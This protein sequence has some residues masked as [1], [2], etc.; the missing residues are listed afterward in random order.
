[1]KKLLFIAIVSL[2]SCVTAYRSEN[3]SN[4]SVSTYK[5]G[6]NTYRVTRKYTLSISVDTIKNK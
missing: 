4:T 6:G 3:I 2:S 1:M 5:K